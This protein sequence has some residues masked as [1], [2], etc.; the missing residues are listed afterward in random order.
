MCLAKTKVYS[1]TIQIK[2]NISLSITS[3]VYMILASVQLACGYVW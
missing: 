2:Y 1:F 3:G